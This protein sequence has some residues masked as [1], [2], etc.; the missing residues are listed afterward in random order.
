MRHVNQDKRKVGKKLRFLQKNLKKLYSTE[1]IE[2]FSY[3]KVGDFVH[4]K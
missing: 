2:N 1:K 4:K 3:K